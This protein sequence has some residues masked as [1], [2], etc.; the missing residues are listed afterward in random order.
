MRTFLFFRKFSYFTAVFKGR[1]FWANTVQRAH[2]SAPRRPGG[3]CSALRHTA[4]SCTTLRR[5]GGEC[6]APGENTPTAVLPSLHGESAEKHPA[7]R[8]SIPPRST[9]G[10]LAAPGG[11]M[12]HSPA[13][14]GTP[15]H[16]PA[17]CGPPLTLAPLPGA[18]SPTTLRRNGP[19]LPLGKVG[20]DML[21]YIKSHERGVCRVPP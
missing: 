15:H 19:A 20:K 3:E 2:R 4:H 8:H 6:S 5:P 17:L 18:S 1:L 11:K 12:L 10:H 16:S 14:P 13:P 21:K 7:L 9:F